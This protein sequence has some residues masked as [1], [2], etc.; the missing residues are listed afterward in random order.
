MTLKMKLKVCAPG[1]TSRAVLANL[2]AIKLVDVA[3]PTTDGRWLI[4]P[5][6]TEPEAQQMMIL[7]KL[8]L[9]LSVHPPPRI[10][11]DKIE[12]PAQTATVL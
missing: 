7:E 11:G 9:E 4:L 8:R 12:L 2:S 10:R 6:C 5:R 3:V 1:L